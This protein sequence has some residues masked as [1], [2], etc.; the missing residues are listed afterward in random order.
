MITVNGSLSFGVERDG[1]V[2]RDFVMRAPTIAD[3]IL[4]IETAGPE[5]SNLRLRIF[6]AA[7]QIESLGTL[8]K[9]E[10]T[11]DLLLMLPEDDIE[12]I[13]SAQDEVGKKQKGLSQSSSPTSS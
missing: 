1:V 10:I 12:P 6:K 5:S 4:A 7:V 3:A 11:G 8:D 13:F 2:H 9:Q